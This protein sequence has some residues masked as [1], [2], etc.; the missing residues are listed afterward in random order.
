[1]TKDQTRTFRGI[2]SLAA[3]SADK[4]RASDVDRVMDEA[5]ES[6]ILEPFRSWMLA[7]NLTERTREQIIAWVA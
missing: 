4:L 6:R 7:Q 1:M 3:D 5:N 2:L